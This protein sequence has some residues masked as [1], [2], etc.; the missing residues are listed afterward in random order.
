MSSNSP[1]RF[2]CI[3]IIKSISFYLQMH[4]NYYTK[5]LFKSRTLTTH[6]FFYS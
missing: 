2:Y 3:N 1:Y 4:T 6:Y 5:D